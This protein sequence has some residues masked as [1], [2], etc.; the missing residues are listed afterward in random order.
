MSRFHDPTTGQFMHTASGGNVLT[1]ALIKVVLDTTEAEQGLAQI[2]RTAT[3]RFGAM[4]SSTAAINMQLGRMGYA[5]TRAAAGMLTAFS[6][7]LG[8]AIQ[9]MATDLRL[10]LMD[11]RSHQTLAKLSAQANAALGASATTAGAQINAAGNVA[12]VGWAKLLG[13]MTAIAIAIMAIITLVQRLREASAKF[14]EEQLQR[15]D[16]ERS[17]RESQLTTMQQFHVA[18][19]KAVGLSTASSI[20]ELHYKMAEYW[21]ASAAFRGKDLKSQKAWRDAS[22]EIQEYFL[23]TRNQIIR[24]AEAK[25][26]KAR[27][28]RISTETT[29]YRRWYDVTT[30]FAQE[31][32][33]SKLEGIELELAKA[34]ASRSKREEAYRRELEDGKLV[35]WRYD[36]LMVASKEAAASEE[37]AIAR[38]YRKK[39]VEEDMK[40]FK[41]EE[42]A[43][44]KFQAYMTG[45]Y[46]SLEQDIAQATLPWFD[47]RLALI[48]AERKEREESAC[49]TIKDSTELE[50]A[51]AKIDDAASAKSLKVHIEQ[52]DQKRSMTAEIFRETDRTT[53][54]EILAL[55][56][57]VEAF[58]EAGLS[59]I[60]I[61][62]YVQARLA[63]IIG[64]GTQ[65]REATWHERLGVLKEVRESR[66]TIQM[67]APPK[68]ADA[69][70]AKEL[71]RILQDQLQTGN[72]SLEVLRKILDAIKNKQ[73]VGTF[74]P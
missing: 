70:D 22:L 62:E 6:P 27:Q 26:S 37:E 12:V 10:M 1:E 28:E 25:E 33:E 11:L 32:V 72:V 44:K 53:A 19:L 74:S 15:L 47:Y 34:K 23:R 24:D 56:K 57:R 64:G 17:K 58:R 39:I 52:A 49:D 2:Q 35:R 30:E 38:K 51:L 59:E 55:Q 40:R 36:A 67:K 65:A 8:T 13:P 29:Q 61:Q 14:T 21:E 3:A 46:G 16:Q 66:G 45:L 54:A 42:A 20:Q 50:A 31:A 73:T 68:E 41:A 9:A 4:G 63:E 7:A 60:R 43:A 69:K 48:E 5:G 18:Y 71:D